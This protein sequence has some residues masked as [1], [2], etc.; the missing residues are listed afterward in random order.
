MRI[1]QHAKARG[2]G[3]YGASYRFLS[4]FR[5]RDLPVAVRKLI[6]DFAEHCRRARTRGLTGQGAAN[7]VGSQVSA[8]VTMR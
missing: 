2:D 8:L 7:R 4:R 6:D 5:D 3:N 1:N